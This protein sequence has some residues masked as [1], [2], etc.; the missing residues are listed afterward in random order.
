VARD[1]RKIIA[2]QHAYALTLQIYQ[3]TADF[4]SSER[5]GITS[6]LR[7]AAASVP[8][9]IAEGSSRT[10]HADYLRFLEIALG[11]LRETECFL[12]LAHDLNFLKKEP[13][14]ELNARTDEAGRTLSGLISS[15]REQK[16]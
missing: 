15:M 9:N 13:F 16:A 8:A 4:P 7:R 12:M 5:Y 11:S 6:Q 10:S 2:W 1:F 3:A 14:Q